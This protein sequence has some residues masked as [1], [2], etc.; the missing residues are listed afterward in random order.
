MAWVT[1]IET[2]PRA[3]VEDYLALPDDV[4]AEL[5]AGELVLTPAPNTDHQFVVGALYAHMRA[6]TRRTG[7]GRVLL[8]PVDVH[9]PTGDVVQPDIVFVRSGQIGVIRD[10][11]LAGGPDLLVEVL[12]PSGVVRDRVF[13]RDAYAR[14]GVSEYWVVDV[15]ERTV[16]VYRRRGEAFADPLVHKPGHVITS[17]VLPD[18]KLPA[19]HLFEDLDPA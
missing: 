6:H 8:S 7:V 18:L 5:L 12:S 10:T 13:K 4:R 16:D 11:H 2:R 15:S 9:L 14:S 17:W 19:V 3:T 1:G